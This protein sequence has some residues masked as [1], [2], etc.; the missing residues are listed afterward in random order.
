MNLALWITTGFLAALFL[1]A[2]ISKL[3]VPQE[4][5]ATMATATQWAADFP[6][7]ALK[8]IGTLELLGALG[9]I[10]PA[11]LDTAPILVPLAALGLALVMTGAITLRIRRHEYALIAAEALYLAATLFIVWGRFGPES[12]N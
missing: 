11:A 12:F 2:G 6:P 9:L 5:M 4:K 7:T 1:G 10:L 8:T 3:L